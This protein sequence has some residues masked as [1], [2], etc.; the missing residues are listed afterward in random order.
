MTESKTDK[1]VARHRQVN[2]LQRDKPTYMKAKK[3]AIDTQ[4][5]TAGSA[6]M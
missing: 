5:D 2:I 3:T 1:Q 4:T 6:D